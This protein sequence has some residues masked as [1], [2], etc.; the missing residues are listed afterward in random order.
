[1]AGH[2]LMLRNI[3]TPLLFLV[4][5]SLPLAATAEV[6]TSVNNAY[7][8]VEGDNARDIWADVLAKSPVRQNGKQ[9][10]A[11]TK[12][13]VSWQ[14]WW[15]DNT[16]SCRISRVTTRLEVTYTLPRLNRTSSIP[17]SVV[18]DWDTYYAALFD[19]ELG[20]KDLGSRAA[21]EIEHQ[22]LN[23][24]TRRSCEQL[25]SDANEIGKTVIA[26]YSR[27]EKEY[28][29]KT[30]HGLNTGAVFP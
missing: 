10:T 22:I 30:N 27:I 6:E 2:C 23:M 16:N 25:E 14:F 24:G 5:C 8:M 17:D 7:Y 9:Y 15:R 20:H 3:H 29:R 19:H 13:N 4:F 26:R 12:W 18:T 11:H 21:A 28:D 1:M